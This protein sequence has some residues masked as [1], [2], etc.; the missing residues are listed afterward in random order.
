MIK[1]I[2]NQIKRRPH[3]YFSV[4]CLITVLCGYLLSYFN[5]G[6][7]ARRALLVIF[8]FSAI[9]WGYPLIKNLAK[10][11]ITRLRAKQSGNLIDIEAPEFKRLAE[12]MKVKLDKKHP[13]VLQKDLDGAYC[14]PQNKR[15]VF[16]EILFNRLTPIE[17]LAI[18][19]HELAHL[20]Q[21]PLVKILILIIISLT[22]TTFTLRRELDW[23][24]FITWLALSLAIYPYMIRKCEYEADAEAANRTSPETAISS[25]KKAEK[26]EHWDR[27][28][29]THPS[30]NK[31]IQNL[32][33]N[34]KPSP[35]R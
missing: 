12:E 21:S 6:I 5:N 25:L 13:F 28:T 27:E 17:R 30:I 20:Q 8:Y 1:Y 34:R 2:I 35:Y 9:I 16:G 7:S 10:V 4:V 23:I 31:R 32:S 14:D 33:R 24:F 3:I 29:V 18:L 22:L 26:K 11:S 15:V 19:S